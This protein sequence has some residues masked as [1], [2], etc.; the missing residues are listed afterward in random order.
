[1][2]RFLFFIFSIALLFASPKVLFA[3]NE[4]SYDASHPT[5]DYSS[6]CVANTYSCSCTSASSVTNSSA[7]SSTASASGCDTFCASVHADSFTYSCTLSS[8]T[9]AYSISQG[10][11]GS[12]KTTT[13]TVTAPVSEAKSYIVPVLNIPLPTLST[14]STPLKDST[15]GNVM[16][17]FLA[18]YI[19]AAYRFLLGAGALVAVVMMMIGGLQYTLARGKAKY[20]DKAKTRITNAITGMVLLLAAYNIGY[21]I[22]PNIVNLKALT[23]KSVEE[24]QLAESVQGEEGSGSAG[25]VISGSGSWEKL[26]EPYRTI[27]QHAKEK[28]ACYV[29]GGLSSPTGKLPNQGNHHWYDRGTNGNWKKI[30]AMDWAAPWGQ[31]IAAPFDGVVTYQQQKDTGN[32]CGN[33]IYM[34]SSDGTKI[35]ICHAKDFTDDSGIYQATRTVTRGQTIGHLGGVCCSGS[36][37]NSDWITKC[38]KSTKDILCT[39]PTQKQSC[40]CQ[41]I[42]EAGNTTGPHVHIT[43]G[44]KGNIL[45]C[46]E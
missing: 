10:A 22:D 30:T 13:T 38:P 43:W 7:S 3:I 14:L 6:Q 2:N 19:N 20:I 23:V 24:I 40:T 32:M 27:V 28:G 37:P 45:S 34:Q 15:G 31:A 42:Q 33:R 9:A 12:T 17:S 1:M 25:V 21:L 46:L 41:K 26:K 36:K 16:V 35:T 18:D 11:V 4:A 29:S 44:G 5:K 39:D 8:G